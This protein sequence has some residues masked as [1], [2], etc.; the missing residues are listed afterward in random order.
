VTEELCYTPAAVV[1]FLAGALPV[2]VAALLA[3]ALCA[4]PAAVWLRRRRRA[5]PGPAFPLPNTR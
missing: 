3:G 4:A 1:A 2:A 5:C